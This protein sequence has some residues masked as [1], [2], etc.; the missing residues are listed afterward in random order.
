VL[1]RRVDLEKLTL[2][3]FF[4][5]MRRMVT[6][7]RRWRPMSHMRLAWATLFGGP[8]NNFPVLG[9]FLTMRVHPKIRGIE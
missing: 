5:R 7:V 8:D 3:F 1:N 6:W 9:S 4:A 2:L